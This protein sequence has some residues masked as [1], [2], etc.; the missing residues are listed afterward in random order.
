MRYPTATSWTASAKTPD[1]GEGEERAHGDGG[2]GS[3]DE[4][5]ENDEEDRRT[6]RGVVI[7]DDREEGEAKETIGV[8]PG[9]DGSHINGRVE[10]QEEKVV[11][12]ALLSR[13]PP[14]LVT[15]S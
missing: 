5:E 13:T 11:E 10:E 12:G 15:G 3:V 1:A 2:T 8:G 9:A 6:I 14:T 4:L 7:G